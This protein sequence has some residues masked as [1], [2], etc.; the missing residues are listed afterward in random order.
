MFDS[1]CYAMLGADAHDFP[2]A[3]GEI[4]SRV[5]GQAQRAEGARFSESVIMRAGGL[6]RTLRL[7]FVLASVPAKQ[8]GDSDWV[9]V[10]QGTMSCNLADAIRRSCLIEVYHDILYIVCTIQRPIDAEV[11]TW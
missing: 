11:G 3:M 8:L 2:S 1:G 4:H 5:S 9:F 7:R 10:G 6:W